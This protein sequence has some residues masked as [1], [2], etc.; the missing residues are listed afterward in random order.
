MHS[1]YVQKA[2]K[3]ISQWGRKLVALLFLISLINISNLGSQADATN[4]R[5][6]SV[7]ADGFRQTILTDA[8]TVGEVLSDADISVSDNDLV[9]PALDTDIIS[10]VFSVN[11]YRARPV[12]VVDGD[13]KHQVL[14]AFD[15][16]KLI[17]EAAG[18]RVFNEDHFKFERINDIVNAG[19]IGERLIISRSTPVK[20]DLFGVDVK[21]RTHAKT[22]GSILSEKGIDIS[23]ADIV[24][25][26]LSTNIKPNQAIKIISVD[27]EVI[28]KEEP[29]NFPTQTIHDSN[30]LSGYRKVQ[31]AGK[32]G[33][34]LVTYEIE[35]HNGQE[36][37]RRIVQSVVSQEPVKQ[38]EVVG[39]KISDGGSNAAIGQRLAAAR[40]WTGAQWQC[41]YDLWTKESNW[42]HL[43]QNPSSG[44]YGIP[45]SLPAT[46]MASAGADWSTNPATQ[47]RWGLNYIAGR[48]GSP[49]AA[50]NFH[51][52][53]NWY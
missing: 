12:V 36:V 41:L 28:A 3:F 6:V 31:Q 35:L 5:V 48:Y 16:P 4:S 29:V 27:Q 9:E 40:G 22:V 21:Y 24:T 30:R 44:A 50:N 8:L 13:S 39:T 42:N 14:T 26:K 43:A 18:L 7:F 20:I 2:G 53:N 33:V 11:V 15:S 19:T 46:K 47:I 38:I 34:K 49:C 17:A 45:Q 52:S 32:P 23:A 51:I 37:S 1:N 10:N 25:P